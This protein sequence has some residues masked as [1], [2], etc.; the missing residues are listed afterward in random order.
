MSVVML[1][2]ST[3]LPAPDERLVMP[4]C[5]YEI[6]DGEVV[7]VSPAFEPHGRQHSKLSALLEAHCAEGYCVAVDMLTR[8]GP[9]EDFAPDA[10]VYPIARDPVT[11]GRQLEHLAFEIVVSESLGHAGKKAASLVRRGVR[12]VFAVDVER[13]RVLEWSRA[14]DGWE[15]LGPDA[16]IED[17]TLVL[18]LAT[19]ELLSVGS[20][21]DAVARALV[22]KGNA[23]I[24]RAVEEGREEGR[25]AG[26]AEGRAQG[27]VHAILGVLAARGL[28]PSADERSRILA[29]ADDDVLARWLALAVGCARVAEILDT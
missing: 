17:P 18:P 4:D 26:L 21:D 3:E 23:A 15:I 1:S 8:A 16:T 12:R 6:V 25:E 2:R 27:R 14:T 11:G 22:A 10:S 7:A 29:M 5:G 9:R 20:A 28:V 24:R 19:E 13:E